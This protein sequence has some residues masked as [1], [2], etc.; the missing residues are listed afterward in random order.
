MSTQ[1]DSPERRR[2]ISYTRSRVRTRVLIVIA[3]VVGLACSALVHSSRLFGWSAST[4]MSYPEIARV[5]LVGDLVLGALALCL[6]PAALRHDEEE[7]D[8]A[9]IGPPSALVAGLVI[10]A[11][12]QV[13]PLA[14]AAGAIVI[15]SISGRVSLTWTVPTACA[16]ILSVL[17]SQLAFRPHQTTVDWVAV[18]EATIVAGVLIAVGTMRGLYLRSMARLDRRDA[19]IRAAHAAPSAR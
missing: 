10:V 13:A 16:A 6:L 14:F 3:A 17:I 9:Y 18:L 7:A 12:W 8:D 5:L 4:S 2:R 15:I 19:E 1:Q 11:L